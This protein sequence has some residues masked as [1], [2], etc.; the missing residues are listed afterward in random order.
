MLLWRD[1][2]NQYLISM[3]PDDSYKVVVFDEDMDGLDGRV[4]DPVCRD[5]NNEH[6]VFDEL[7]SWHF[8]QSVLANMKEAREHDFAGD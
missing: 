8:G 7:L 4:F 3:N 1:I 5:P 2:H 6:H